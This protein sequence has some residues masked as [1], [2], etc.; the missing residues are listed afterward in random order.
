[1]RGLGGQIEGWVDRVVG[2]GGGAG[3]EGWDGDVNAWGWRVGGHGGKEWW[4]SLTE[5]SW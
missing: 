3:E 4:L 5:V 1:M 2:W